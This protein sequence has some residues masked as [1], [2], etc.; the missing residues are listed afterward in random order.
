[1]L[2]RPLLAPLDESADGG[3]RC[4]EDIYIVAVD[5]APKAI[6]LRKIRRAFIHKAGRAAL[7]RSVHDITVSGYPPDV[8]RTPV[9]VLFF[10]VEDVLHRQISSDRISP[11]RMHHTLG[12]TRD[13]RRVN[14]VQRVLSVERLSRTLVRY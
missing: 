3:R 2:P 9:R 14:D 7:Q 13:S 4:V 12:L 1:M 11:G 10:Q 8:G 6:R 5:D